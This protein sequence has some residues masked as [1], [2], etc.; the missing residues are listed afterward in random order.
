MLRPD[1][2]ILLGLRRRCRILLRSM[3]SSRPVEEAIPKGHYR[4]R[5]RRTNQPVE[6]GGTYVAACRNV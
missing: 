4:A 2:R 6:E 1:L 5:L 3:R